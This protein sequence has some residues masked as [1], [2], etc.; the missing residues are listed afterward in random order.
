MTELVTD[1]FSQVD[2]PFITVATAHGVTLPPTL[3]DWSVL[4]RRAADES[5][6]P[7]ARLQLVVAAHQW[8]P[9]YVDAAF[10]EFAPLDD[11]ITATVLAT[12]MAERFPDQRRTAEYV[13]A[14]ANRYFDVTYPGGPAFHGP[15]RD[16]LLL[17]ANQVWELPLDVYSG[18]HPPYAR[19]W[20]RAAIDDKSNWTFDPLANRWRSPAAASVQ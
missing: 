1:D 16:M 5:T 14:V 7:T 3:D 12:A 10:A 18:T 11:V 20:L 2:E 8:G 6:V 17:C 15:P 9:T 19:R 13:L 4:L